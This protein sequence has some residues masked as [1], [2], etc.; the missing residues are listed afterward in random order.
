MCFGYDGEGAL[1]RSLE[2]KGASRRSLFRGAALGAAGVAAAGSG[3]ASGLASTAAAGGRHGDGRSRGVPHDRI[4]IQLYTLRAALGGQPGFD[5]VLQRL[6]QYGYTRVELA[7]YYGRTAAQLRTFLDGLG[8]RATSSHDGL[9]ADRTALRTK[10]ENAAT[11][12]QRYVVVPYLASNSLAEWQGWAD[13]MNEEAA[14]AKRYGL[15]YGYHNH[16]HEFTTDLGGGVTPWEVLTERLDPRLVHLEV[17]LYWAYTGGVN[18]GA[19]DPDRFAIDVVRRAP[20]EV[21]QF[22]VKDRDA[23]TG[24]M[25]DLGTGV[26]DFARILRRHRVEEYIVENDTPDVSPLTSAAVGRLYLEHLRF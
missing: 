18:T 21:R 1:R 24:D 23:A 19:A 3:L 8:I 25:S 13:R 7:G 10:L 14:L 15:R 17:D 16:A 12:G 26:V 5:V 22:H 9:S 4:S 11:L 6:A 20:Q 2:E